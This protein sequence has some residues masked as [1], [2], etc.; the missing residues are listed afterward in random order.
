MFQFAAMLYAIIGTSVAG[1]F[2]IAALVS[3]NDTLM[4]ILI[5][6]AAGAVVGIPATYFVT[7]AILSN[8]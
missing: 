4:P 7:K 2:I 1:I 6:A 3:G 5:A 8:R